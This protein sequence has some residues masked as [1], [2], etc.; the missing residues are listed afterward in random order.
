MKWVETLWISHNVKCVAMS[1][2]FRHT[3]TH[4]HTYRLADTHTHTNTCALSP[5]SSTCHLT[6][7]AAMKA[8]LTA[9]T[10]TLRWASKVP[11]VVRHPPAGSLMTFPSL[12]RVQCRRY[13]PNFMAVWKCSYP[14][15]PYNRGLCL[16]LQRKWNVVRPLYPVF[17]PGFVGWPMTV[18]LTYTCHACQA[19]DYG[20]ASG[21]RHD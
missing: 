8:S 19:L 21:A 3:H 13:T 7:V 10:Q 15:Q 4:T 20:T 9:A 5:L 2:I 12:W 14:P 11:P 18:G 1:D 16:V 17:T 6:I